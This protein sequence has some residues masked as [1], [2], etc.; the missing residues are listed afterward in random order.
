MIALALVGCGGMGCR[1]IRGLRK[2]LD[3]GSQTTQLIAVCDPIAANAENAANLAADL[4]G[5]RP[6]IFSSV[7]ELLQA[8]IGLDAVMITT[9]PDMHAEVGIAA[10][11]AGLHVMVEKPITLTVEEGALLVDAGL[12]ADRMLAVAEN[13]RRDPINRLAKALVDSEVLGRIHLVVQSSAG[14]G[15]NVIITPWRHRRRSGGIVVD[16]GI[17]YADLVEYFGGPVETIYGMSSCVDHQRL[18]ADGI[19]YEADAEDLEV[20]VMRFS[21]GAI[22]SLMMNLAGRGE[23]HF[24][25]MIYGSN[26]SLS[27]PLDRTG[28]ALGVTLRRNGQDIPVPECDLLAMVPG[29]RLDDVTSRLFGGDRLTSYSME[30]VDIDANLLAIE[31]ADFAQAIVNHRQPEVNGHAGLRSLAISNGL[32]ESELLGKTLSV[33]D[34]LTQ[35]NLPYQQGLRVAVPN[36]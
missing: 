30:F 7:D 29:Y 19:W 27:I 20:G 24:S 21:N 2:L 17:H 8:N 5:H 18:G 15:E 9:S 25:R 34:V 3:I 14:S 28:K 35:F 32:M 4:L 10:F 33:N 26:G 11:A 12:R 16:M 36:G 22:C 31:H 23:S 13:Y 1:H 6:Q